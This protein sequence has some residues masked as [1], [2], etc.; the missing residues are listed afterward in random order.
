M[1]KNYIITAINN[2]L[3]NKLYGAINIIGLAV[4]LAA[5]ILI[6][7]YVQD[8]LSY[9]KHWEKSDLIYRVNN[10]WT[11]PDTPKQTSPATSF[12]VLPSLINFFPE[13]IELGTRIWNGIPGVIQVDNKRYP[14]S[15]PQVIKN[16]LKYSSVKYSAGV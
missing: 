7:L 12:P 13:D 6:T 14:G 2:L 3:K 10:I 1:L 8:E 4:G 11:L 9:D 15:I 5:C 16:F